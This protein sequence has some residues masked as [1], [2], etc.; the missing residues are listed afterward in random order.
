MLFFSGILFC[1]HLGHVPVSSF[2][3][4]LLYMYIWLGRVAMFSSLS[5]V[6][7]YNRCPTGASG[8]AS[9]VTSIGCFKY[10]SCASC[11]HTPVVVDLDC[12]WHLNKRDIPLGWSAERTTWDCNRGTA[13][14]R[15]IQWNRIC[16]SA[17]IW[18]QM[19]FSWVCHSWRGLGDVLQPK[20][21]HQVC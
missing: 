7:S 5:R 16:F 15:L 1:F 21:V 6:T 18:C 19:S 11:V 14:Q 10:E 17:G 2:L 8:T 12:C 4:P 3:A 9:S 20:A 13:V